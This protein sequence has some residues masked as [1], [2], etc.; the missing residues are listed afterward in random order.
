MRKSVI[1]ILIVIVA[2]AAVLGWKFFENRMSMKIKN[3]GFTQLVAEKPMVYLEFFD[4]GKQWDNFKAS[5]FYSSL[6]HNQL[7]KNVVSSDEWGELKLALKNLEQQIGVPINEENIKAVF[8]KDF[9]IAVFAGKSTVGEEIKNSSADGNM[10]APVPKFI[11]DFELF[12]RLNPKARMGSMVM[13]INSWIHN[14]S[15]YTKKGYKGHSYYQ[16]TTGSPFYPH[17]N[18]FSEKGILILSNREGY[19]YASVDKLESEARK[20]FS[21]FLGAPPADC[22]SLTYVDN[23][24]Y[25]KWL[26]SIVKNTSRAGFESRFQKRWREITGNLTEE[27][28]SYGTWDGGLQFEGKS[29]IKNPESLLG[30]L[31]SRQPEEVKMVKYLPSDVFLFWW[32]NSVDLV[33]I[34]K[35]LDNI[36]SED[37]EL[38]RIYDSFFD[39]VQNGHGID[40]NRLISVLGPKLA[41]ALV[42]PNVDSPITLP[43]VLSFLETRDKDFVEKVITKLVQEPGHKDFKLPLALGMNE[44]KKDKFTLH[45]VPTPVSLAPGYLFV[46]SFLVS[47]IRL[48]DFETVMNL[49]AR[50]SK[51]SISETPAF[52]EVIPAR[53]VNN[54]F[55]LNMGGLLTTIRELIDRYPV[56]KAR[57]TQEDEENF[58]G[59]MELLKVVK[60]IGIVNYWEKPVVEFSFKM[61]VKDFEAESYPSSPEPDSTPK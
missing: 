5:N 45:Y 46:D 61:A 20:P 10:A 16:I 27:T 50:N 23:G 22:I 28:V 6:K 12:L 34:K 37:Q 21:D 47:G 24:K 55:Y 13:D 35:L 14:D 2:A 33:K 51:D 56:V 53:K 40:V 49:A 15:S 30:S 8:G 43:G 58:Q 19:I 3:V 60:G 26:D 9:A 17:I 39:D 7:V 18:F 54:L 57:W 1:A 29:K 38:K 44:V 52:R 11:P 4:M 25:Q 41:L 32:S 36:V 59:M 42:P 48:S 31:I